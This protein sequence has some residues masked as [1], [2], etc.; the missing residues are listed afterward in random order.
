LSLITK[1]FDSVHL[2]WGPEVTT[3]DDG[4]MLITD[5]SRSPAAPLTRRVT[6]SQ[7][8]AP[9]D[10]NWDEM[11]CEVVLECSGAFLTRAKL[12]PFFDKGVKKVRG[13]AAA[14]ERALQP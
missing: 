12:Q 6:Y 1:Q 7:H 8:K 5:S 14:L 11:G 9:G 4:A 3:T 2:Q 13:G 10:V